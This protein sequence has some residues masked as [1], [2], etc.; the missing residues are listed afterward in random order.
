MSSEELAEKEMSFWDHLE[1]LRGAIIRSVLLLVCAFVALFFFKNLV[2]DTIVLAPT[3]SS[4]WFYRLLGVNMNLQLI[5]IDVT[6]QFFTHIKVTFIAA[7][8]LTFPFICYQL[9]RF[10]APA[11]YRDEKKTVRRAF[12]LGAGLFYLGICTGYFLVVPLMLLFFDGYQVSAAIVNTFSLNSY[13]SIFSGMVF[14]MGLL[15]EFPSVLAVLSHFGIVTREFMKRYR[16]HAIVVIIILAA[17]LTP[18]GDPFTL[19]VV[20]VPLYLLYE[21]SILICRPER[22]EI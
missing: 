7:F 10:I 4:F 2:F 1:E 22:E 18:T 21:F 5:N 11:L 17:V 9:W 15:F 16:R 19:L 6:A 3:R 13:I 14:M 8:V 12:G 20:S